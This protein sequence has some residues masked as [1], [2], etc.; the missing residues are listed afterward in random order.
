MNSLALRRW[1]AREI[2]G[3]DI[4]RQPLR[5]PRP[6]ASRPAAPARNWK[7][8]SWIR[9]L[10]CA[11]CGSRRFVEAAHTGNDGG[12]RHKASD[13]SCIP[14][15]APCHRVGPRAYHCI[16]RTEFE[17][18]HQLH[19]SRIVRRLKRAWWWMQQEAA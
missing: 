11:A 4:A 1:L 7:Y 12:M 10:P 8:R 9:S 15:C 6:L 17:R 3:K 16:G 18:L 2:L 14:L 5:P 13:Y 19:L